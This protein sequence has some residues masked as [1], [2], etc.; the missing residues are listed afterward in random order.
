MLRMRRRAGIRNLKGMSKV[1]RKY[2]IGAWSQLV[3]LSILGLI[4]YNMYSSEGLSISS[5]SFFLL[6]YILGG[7]FSFQ[8]TM[9]RGK[10]KDLQERLAKYEPGSDISPWRKFLPEFLTHRYVGVQVLDWIWLVVF[11]FAALFFV[12]LIG[13]SF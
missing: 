13:G 3:F 11:V 9:Q 7:I 5:G 6:L 10:I 12:I 4:M 1:K 8:H 2:I